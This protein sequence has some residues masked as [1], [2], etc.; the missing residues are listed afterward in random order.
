MTGSEPAPPASVPPRP[1]L[2]RRGR[3]LARSR[4]PLSRILRL[5]AV[6]GTCAL[7]VSLLTDDPSVRVVAPLFALLLGAQL[8]PLLRGER[9]D[10]FEPCT[11]VGVYSAFGTVA[12]IAAFSTHGSLSL[13][14]L[15]GLPPDETLALVIQVLVWSIIGIVAYYL[16]YYHPRWG[17]RL[18]RLVPDPA[19]A[20]WSRWRLHFVC[21]GLLA[22]FVAAYGF[23]QARVGVALTDATQLAA[24]K[25]A[26]RDDASLSWMGRGIQFGF[27]ASFLYL[28]A[29][30]AR[31]GWKSSLAPVLL[32]VLNAWLVSRVGQRGLYLYPV[33]AALGIFHYTRRRIPVAL[34]VGLL[35]V[36]L[37]LSNIQLMWRTQPGQDVQARESFA[38]AAADPAESLAFHE[39]ERQRFSVLALV[40]YAF[41]NQHDHLL[42]ETYAGLVASFIPRWLWT[43][44]ADYFVWRDT[45]IVP[46][47]VGARTPTS[48]LGVLYVNWSYPGII[49]GM[50]LW[51]VFQRATYVALQRAPSDPGSTLLYMMS[52][53]F[54]QPTMLGIS[55]A[56][57][58]L[59]PAYV[60]LRFIGW[61]RRGRPGSSRAVRD[62]E[63]A[64]LH[65]PHA[66]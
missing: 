54:L 38:Q 2:G 35:L 16:G 64:R 22:A 56:I 50:I 37:P 19:G 10:L 14:F 34:F 61:P 48:F 3:V 11:F 17:G 52:L 7:A 36:A 46:N 8:F 40:F 51:G 39:S 65:V 53:V 5:L 21:F 33:L 23:F 43:D 25:A 57:Q 9:A 41:P 47:L 49:L 66:S 13:Q 63:A 6:L 32:V 45:S 28:V 20:V 24:G 58:Y 59:L 42:G 18:A 4:R 27:L 44:K 60:A 26:W 30:G 62:A 55:S 12:S 31:R 29:T 1:G 15:E